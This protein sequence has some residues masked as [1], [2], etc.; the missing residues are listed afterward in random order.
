MV[1]GPAC[2]AQLGLSLFCLDGQ[3]EHEL[4]VVV[5][6]RLELFKGRGVSERRPL[7]P[8]VVSREVAFFDVVFDVGLGDG[9]V[10]W[11]V[12]VVLV[13]VE[14]EG[15]LCEFIA[16]EVDENESLFLAGNRALIA[17]IGSSESII[18]CYHDAS[19]LC[20]FEFFDG[21]FGL[22]LEFVLEHLES[23]EYEILF[24]LLA[25]EGLHLLLVEGLAPDR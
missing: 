23:V 20:F 15:F 14:S 12:S 5:F 4:L 10:C 13:V 7:A 2:H 6:H 17:D 19:Y 3:V 16:D 21:S 11:E 24:D 25:V 9:F 22:G 18:S 8:S 1:E